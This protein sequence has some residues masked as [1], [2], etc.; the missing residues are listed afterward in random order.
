MYI[1]FPEILNAIIAYSK[2]EA[3]RLGSYVLTTDHLVLGMIRHS[4]N[5]AVARLLELGIDISAMKKSIEDTIGKGEPVPESKANEIALS[6]AASTALKLMYLEARSLKSPSPGSLHLLLA[7]MRGNSTAAIDYLHMQGIHYATIKNIG[8]EADAPEAPRAS[9]DDLLGGISSAGPAASGDSE[10]GQSAD[11]FAASDGEGGVRQSQTTAT[12]SKTPVLDSFGFDLTKAAANDE[13]DPVV[14]RDSEIDRVAQILGRRKK[15]NPIL[16]GEPGVG[17]SAIAEGLANKIAHKEVPYSLS[18]KRII[19]LDIGSIVAGTKYRGQFEERMK[20]ILNE[21]KKNDDVILFIDELHTL[22]G[23]GGA[24]GSLDAANMLKPALARGEIQ[25][26]GATTLDEFREVIEKDG[27]LERRFQKVMVEPTDFD[28]TLLILQNIKAKYEGHHNV[29]YT[30]EALKSCISLSQRY[31]SDRCLPDKAV[32]IMD[33]A[34]SRAHIKNLKVPKS[35]TELES[36]VSVLQTE[37]SKAIRE[38]N[39]KQASMLRDML[40]TKEEELE[41]ARKKWRT[42]MENNPVVVDKEDIE[43]VLSQSTKIPIQKLAQSESNRLLNMGKTLKESVIGQDEAIDKVTRAILRNRA[44]LKDP[45]KP[46]GTFLFLGPTGVGKTQLAKVLARNLFDTED[47]LIRIDMSEFME[48]FSVSRLIGAPPG[49]IGYNEGGELSEK[50]RRKPYSVVL[51]D[52]IEKAHPDIFNLLL[53]VLDEGRLTDSNGRNIDFRN[54]IL[55]LTSN[56]GTKELKDFGQGVGYATATKRDVVSKNR[57]IIDKALKNHFSPEFLNRLDEQILFNPLTR[58]DLEK[59]IDIELKGLFSR[60]EQIG[61]KLKITPAA[62]KYIAEEGYD[63]QYGARPL[64]RAIQKLV[65]D[66]VSEAII[67]GRF[68]VGETIELGYTDSQIT[69]KSKTPPATT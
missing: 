29:T 49:Y 28:Q 7:I 69:V 58:E 46:I 13:L 2:E 3:I 52:E 22:V 25:C 64:K 62:K 23:A 47:S 34:G 30:D 33:E 59:I 67:S 17:K 60:V 63:P 35:L 55:I 57:S 26:I 19:S 5:A 6:T 54:T 20:A 65:E 66:P 37:K 10:G 9:S 44:G 16:I 53:Q 42:K 21:L 32:D 1:D 50:V 12:Q 56:I 61:Y 18:D 11:S 14:A 38:K 40:K 31:I 43:A 48:K 41:T 51:L 27:A 39:F 45:G 24:S 68:Q 36:A 15:N 8:P 4:D